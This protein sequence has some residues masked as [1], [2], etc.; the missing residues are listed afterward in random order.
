MPSFIFLPMEL[1]GGQCLR[2]F[3][4]WQTVYTYFR[5][6]ESDGTWRGINQQLREQV[7]I[8]VGRNPKPSAG[9]IDSQSVKF[10]RQSQ[11]I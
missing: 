2:D 1:N 11:N 7:R 4:K 6:W 5:G 10:E 3:P 8:E 9:S